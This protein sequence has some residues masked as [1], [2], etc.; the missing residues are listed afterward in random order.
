MAGQSP[1]QKQ[2]AIR[3]IQNLYV[4]TYLFENKTFMLPVLLDLLAFM[5]KIRAKQVQWNDSY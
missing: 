1:I 3:I 4:N 2:N 5:E